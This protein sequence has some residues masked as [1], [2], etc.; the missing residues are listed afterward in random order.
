VVLTTV[1]PT[2]WAERAYYSYLALM[3]SCV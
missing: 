3:Q 1:G 2:M